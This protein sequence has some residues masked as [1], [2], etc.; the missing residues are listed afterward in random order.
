M[1]TT[2][3][4]TGLMAELNNL[5]ESFWAG[6]AEIAREFLLAAYEPKDHV[7]WLLHQCYREL[8][9]PGLLDRPS[10]RTRWIIDNIAAG[11]PAAE[12]AEGRTQLKYQLHQIAEEFD[13]FKLYADI[14][15]D[16]LGGPVKMEDMRD[17]SLPSDKVIE[18][19]RVK[20]YAENE[21]LARLAYDFTEGGGAGI[22]YA[23]GALETDDP[24]LLR[25]KDAGRYIYDDEVPHGQHGVTG[26]ELALTTAEEFPKIREMIV[27]IC[28]ERLR[29][30]AEMHNTT[31][32]EERIGEIEAGKIEPLKPF[33]D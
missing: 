10:S 8:R 11:L 16:I 7:H 18:D 26:I 3:E 2:A 31:I 17:L 25:I 19:L 13:H 6:E 27:E 23:Q 12:T 20:L 5:G 4:L 22:F 9:G 1:T 24:L 14:L 21:R 32:S 30:R 15:E 28:R 29:M 33:E